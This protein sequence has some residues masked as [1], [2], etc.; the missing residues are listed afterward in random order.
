MTLNNLKHQI[1]SL[2]SEDELRRIFALRLDDEMFAEVGRKLGEKAWGK[3]YHLRV[4]A[5]MEFLVDSQYLAA[6]EDG[7]Y[8][9]NL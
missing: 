8:S 5:G 9:D 6:K 3:D 1:T 4:W 2:Y 7:Q